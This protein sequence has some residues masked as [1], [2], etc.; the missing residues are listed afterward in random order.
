MEN[1]VALF[2]DTFFAD[3]IKSLKYNIIATYVVLPEK[4]PHFEFSVDTIILFD[5]FY[6]DKKYAF[7]IIREAIVHGYNVVSFFK[8]SSSEKES[9]MSLGAKYNVRVDLYDN[10]NTLNDKIFKINVPV[11]FVS[12]MGDYCDQI[13]THLLLSEA[14]KKHGF[15]P[16]N[17]TNSKLGKLCGLYCIDQIL[18]EKCVIVLG[19][20]SSIITKINHWICEELE[21]QLVDVIIISDENG[22]FPY[23]EWR[24][25]DFGLYNNIMKYACPYDYVI[26]NIY[27]KEYSIEELDK[28]HLRSINATNANFVKLGMSHTATAL[29]LPGLYTNDGY[30]KL[31]DVEYDSLLKDINEYFDIIDSCSVDAMCKYVR[32]LIV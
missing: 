27:S 6:I 14:L 12:G 23:D 25:N 28:I 3:R 7:K 4:Y 9:I 29:T 16:L 10:D 20:S 2:P 1:A 32:S 11:F 24:I 17:I 19:E 18:E 22:I 31:I 13:K 21:K 5:G 30:L 15:N 8:L 26:Y